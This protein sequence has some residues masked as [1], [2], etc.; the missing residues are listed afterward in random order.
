[1]RICF[2]LQRR[3]TA[4]AVKTVEMSLWRDVDDLLS[5]LPCKKWRSPDVLGSQVWYFRGSW[6]GQFSSSALL[7]CTRF[8]IFKDHVDLCRATN[9]LSLSLV[10][11]E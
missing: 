1:M 3:L 6:E 4:L 10:V 5:S 2:A 8:Q 9:V 7:E 11:G